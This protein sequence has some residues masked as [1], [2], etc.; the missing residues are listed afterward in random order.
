MDANAISLVYGCGAPIAAQELGRMACRGRRDKC[1]VRGA[2][3]DP[4]IRQMQQKVPVC[5]D[6]EAKKAA[7]K[8]CR[9]EI[10]HH[11]ARGAMRSRQPREHGICL[12]SAMLDETHG[13]VQ[14]TV[15]GAVVFVP[16]C[17]RRDHDAGIGGSYRRIRSSVSRTCSAV[18]G[19]NLASG[20]A[21]TPLPRLLSCIGVDAISISIR[22]SP[23]RISSDWPGFRPSANRSGLGTTILPARSMTVFMALTMP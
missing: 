6:A 2:A 1:V 11:A 4:V 7:S 18:S 9:Q 15:R 12:Q 13:A 14:Q 23:A 3:S 8:P 20:T 10:A 17:E 16:G 21:T 19:G 5:A 22:P